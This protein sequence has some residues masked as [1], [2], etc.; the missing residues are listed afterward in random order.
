MFAA[1]IGIVVAVGVT[2]GS[3]K[4]PTG[5]LTRVT[6]AMVTAAD[7]ASVGLFER[8]PYISDS[9]KMV[10]VL[11]A[12]VSLM[13][14]GVI[15][16]ALVWAAGAVTQARRVLSGVVMLA[17][18]A[19]FLV[20]PAGQ[21]T[22]L[23]TAAG[24]VTATLIVPAGLFASAALWAMATMIALGNA[25]SIYKATSPRVTE[26]TDTF[27]TASGLGSAPFWQLAAIVVGLAPFCGAVML[28]LR[29]AS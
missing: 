1:L 25:A 22:L 11:G 16:M 5:P 29:R 14:P 20:L 9:P 12:V 24:I 6:D 13:V 23:M 18:L 19:S 27:V 26:A 2:L 7:S 3:L 10:D 15:A 28:G 17:A 4:L 21:A 8:V